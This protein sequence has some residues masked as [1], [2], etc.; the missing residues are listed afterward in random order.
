MTGAVRGTGGFQRGIEG[1]AAVRAIQDVPDAPVGSIEFTPRGE[2]FEGGLSGANLVAVQALV[3]VGEEYYYQ[4]DF[5][6]AGGTTIEDIVFTAQFEIP[7]VTGPAAFFGRGTC[8]L[9]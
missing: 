6:N 7:G 1:C 9:R 4:I 5:L 8:C 3:P 2:T